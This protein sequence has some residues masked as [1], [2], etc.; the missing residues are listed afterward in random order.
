MT[1][2]FWSVGEETG[3]RALSDP[4]LVW[5]LAQKNDRGGVLTGLGQKSKGAWGTWVTQLVK[6][7]TRDFSSGHDLK[8]VTSS[9]AS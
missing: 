8:V 1:E 7:L 6:C 9:P 3:G 2:P 5:R 4:C